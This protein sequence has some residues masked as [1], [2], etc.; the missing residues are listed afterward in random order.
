MM[1]AG[2]LA[3]EGGV[4]PD[5]R[6]AAS[7]GGPR[8]GLFGRFD[9]HRFG[10]RLSLRTLRRE[11]VRRGAEVEALAPRSRP[12]P[13]DDGEGFSV[14]PRAARAALEGPV[15]ASGL[16]QLARRYDAL[17]V[18][19]PAGA[20]LP[21]ALEAG[22]AVLEETELALAA[23]WLLEGG[24][25]ARR[26]GFLRRVGWFPGAGPAVVV[27]VADG[28]R[29]ATAELAEALGELSAVLRAEGGPGAALVVARLDGELEPSPLA[30]ALAGVCPRVFAL[31][32]QASLEDLLAAF[33]ASA[34][35]VTD[36]PAAGAAARCLGRPV[37]E[38]SPE[39][40]RRAVRFLRPSPSEASVAAPSGEAAP[41]VAPGTRPEELAARLDRIVE[42][43]RAR[44]RGG[45]AAAALRD[46]VRE[47]RAE[48]GVLRALV[49]ARDRQLA[50]ERVRFADLVT[51]LLAERTEL[52]DRLRALRDEASV[53]VA[54]LERTREAERA[55]AERRL[56]ALE[57]E[58][59]RL[60]S[61]LAAL[62]AT[63]T[64]RYTAGARR[65]Y[66]RLRAALAT[67]RRSR[68]SER[69]AP[70]E[71]PAALGRGVGEGP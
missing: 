67:T 70:P 66:G 45:E 2:R 61:E 55:E 20:D 11:L 50:S 17:V 4:P 52:E 60:A 33:A 1:R 30:A 14:A 65:L 29:Q 49:R 68:G 43:A 19:R 41:P 32:P 21:D 57:D 53:L 63:R 69:R 62:T 44:A 15:R 40:V 34:V 27:G 7:G 71:V 16:E 6:A 39:A 8:V 12:S 46:E 9:R 47:L 25:G 38:P 13:L 42:V 5:A 59:D 23:P 31:G 48:V 24:V 3:G 22:L 37:A 54:D 51:D 36:D 10:D 56:A 18:V 35:V 28:A 58:R 26:L 64:L